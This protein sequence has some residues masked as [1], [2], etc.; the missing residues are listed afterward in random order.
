VSSKII[1]IFDSRFGRKT[2][3]WSR[4]TLLR[5]QCWLYEQALLTISKQ[6]EVKHDPT[7]PSWVTSYGPTRAAKAAKAALEGKCVWDL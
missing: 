2:L 5:Q 7:Q 3:Y 4:K 1:E 6:T